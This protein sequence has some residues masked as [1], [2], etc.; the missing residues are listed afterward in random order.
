MLDDPALD[1]VFYALADPTRRAMLR[2]LADG[3]R[4]ITALV[5]PFAMSFAGASKHIRVLEVAGLVSRRVEGRK[6][7]CRIEPLPLA[8]ADE[9]LRFYEAFWNARL[10]QLTELLRAADR[11]EKSA[12]PIP[13]PR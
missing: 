8:V 12:D 10:D 6:H 7:L 9:W 5:E 4:N 11:T 3:E 2:G 1:R 13:S